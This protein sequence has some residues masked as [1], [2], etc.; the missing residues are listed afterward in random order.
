MLFDKII[1][2]AFSLGAAIV[3]FGAWA[4]IETKEFGDTALTAGLLTET[5]IFCIYGLLEWRKKP[6]AREEVP[7]PPAHPGTPVRKEQVEELTASIRQTAHILNKIFR[8]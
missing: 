3:I 7:A 5:T 4:K 1:N 2:T 6:R 8:V